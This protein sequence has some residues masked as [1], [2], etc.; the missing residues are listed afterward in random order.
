MVEKPV[1][2]KKNCPFCGEEIMATAIICRFCNRKLNNK[3]NS[4]MNNSRILLILMSIIA[5]ILLAGLIVV[6]ILMIQ[7]KNENTLSQDQITNKKMEIANGQA[8]I[9]GFTNLVATND[10]KFSQLT[11]SLSTAYAGQFNA[12]AT[13][14]ALYI[15]VIETDCSPQSV[16]IDY[17]SNSTVSAS[18]KEY[19]GDSDG[20]IKSATWDVIWNNSKTAMHKLSGKYLWVFIVYFNNTE[21]N[22]SNMVYDVTNNCFMKE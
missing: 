21:L 19:V 4:K 5:F 16:K 11:K 17:T 6:T 22:N 13:R 18:L 12:E 15:Q 3:S 8:T 7:A 2:E 10:G 1:P 14:S 20:T 9:T